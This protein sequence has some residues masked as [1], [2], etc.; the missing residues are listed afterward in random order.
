MPW[1]ALPFEAQAYRQTLSAKCGVRGIPCLAVMDPITGALVTSE[2]R[3]DVANYGAEVVSIW[4]SM[5]AGSSLDK[6][7]EIERSSG[8][9]KDAWEKKERE[10]VQASLKGEVRPPPLGE[11]EKKD[12]LAASVKARFG[13]LMLEDKVRPALWLRA[14]VAPLNAR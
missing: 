7:D 3:E 9:S 11:K 1:L 14:R 13:E 6:M 8:S 10:R 2:G 12:M 4:M 5:L